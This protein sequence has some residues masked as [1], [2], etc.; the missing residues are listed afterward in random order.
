MD[1]REQPRRTCPGR[2]GA[3]PTEKEITLCSRPERR[4]ARLLYA[5]RQR[6][7]SARARRRRRLDVGRGRLR[8]IVAGEAGALPAAPGATARRRKSGRRLSADVRG[9]GPV[10]VSTAAARFDP[11]AV[12]ATRCRRRPTSREA[13]ARHLRQHL[14][15]AVTQM[16]AFRARC[17]RSS[18]LS[19]APRG[20]AL[21]VFALP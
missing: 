8:A 6:A 21:F 18:E 4:T 11:A 20:G 10:G 14:C 19:A 13:R 7:Q 2:R 12:R 16:M 15:A 17:T 1:E 9:S 5:P 3:A